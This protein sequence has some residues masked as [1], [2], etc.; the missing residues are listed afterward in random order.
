[1]GN[2]ACRTGAADE[3]IDAAKSSQRAVCNMP[4][5]GVMA[6]ITAHRDATTFARESLGS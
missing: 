2:D 1:M 3:R 4:A 6:D 5:I